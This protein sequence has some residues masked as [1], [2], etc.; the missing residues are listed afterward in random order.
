MKP[1]DKK[2]KVAL[3][4][5]KSTFF[6]EKATKKALVK[7]IEKTDKF[8]MG[9]W[10]QKFE[11]AFAILQN[12]KYCMLF[13]S[14]SSANLAL[15]QALQNLGRLKRGDAIGFSALTWST[16]VMPILQ[17]GFEAIPI[18]C[19]RET[20]NVDADCAVKYLEKHNC[21]AFF[22]TNVLGLTT[23]LERLKKLC[24]KKKIILIEDNCESLGTELP[25]G[26]AGNFGLASTFSFFVAHHLSTIEG[27]MVATDDHELMEMLKIV[28]ANGWDRNLHPERQNHWRTKHSVAS[29]FH[30]RYT[31][32][33]LG[34]NL[35]PTEITGFLGHYQLPHLDKSII[36]REKRFHKIQKI[37]REN[38]HFIPLEHGHIK[39]VSSFAFPFITKT[40]E[41]R[42]HYAEK[43][44]RAGVEIRPI[45]AGNIMRQPFFKKYSVKQHE[46]PET[47]IIHHC[48]FYCG[49]NPDYTNKEINIIIDCI[50]P[51]GSKK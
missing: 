16:N 47:D 14:G 4:G 5:E 13:N 6:N 44:E 36:I 11:E 17:L 25:T 45:I 41:L 19:R 43:F 39:R 33:D 3:V 31:F 37:V 7:F 50:K 29:D 2:Y 49:N 23:D 27:G 24:Q 20:L 35:R 46:L 30:A 21:K 8:S 22:V 1:E 48:G 51:A 15:I 38:P 28:R 10:C 32:Y 42:N 12:R 9:V 18:D 34:Y 26:K 40:P